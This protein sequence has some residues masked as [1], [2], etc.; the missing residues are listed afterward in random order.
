MRS[1][2]LLYLLLGNVCY[3]SAIGYQAFMIMFTMKAIFLD[4]QIFMLFLLKIF[5]NVNV[6]N[7]LVVYVKLRIYYAKIRLLCRCAVV[8]AHKVYIVTQKRHVLT[9]SALRISLKQS[10]CHLVLP[11]LVTLSTSSLRNLDIGAN[12]FCDRAHRLYDAALLSS[13]IL[14][15]LFGLILTLKLIIVGIFSKFNWSTK[16]LNSLTN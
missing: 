1:L 8:P 15:M 2:C 3:I 10:C 14:I 4:Y 11:H 5:V 16:R 13:V 12:K 7:D 9:L 6:I